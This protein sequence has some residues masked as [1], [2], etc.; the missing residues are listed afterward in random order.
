MQN[1][2]AGKQHRVYEAR[3]L[4]DP[5]ERFEDESDDL[6]DASCRDS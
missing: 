2:G 5:L 4:F 3:E 1:V 6:A